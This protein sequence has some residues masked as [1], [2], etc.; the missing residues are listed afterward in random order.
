[1]TH[2]A[3]KIHVPW[4][5]SLGKNMRDDFTEKTR[6]ELRERVGGK[7]S[8]PDCRRETT[9]PLLGSEG[10]IRLGRA[11]HITAASRGGPRFDAALT[12]HQ[13]RSIHNGIWLCCDHADEVDTNRH[14]FPA[15]L[16]R[17]WKALAEDAAQNQLGKPPP[18]HDDAIH[19]VMSVL[20]ATPGKMLPRAM[21]NT[22]AAISRFLREK[23][24]TVQIIPEFHDGQTN[25]R[26]ESSSPIEIELSA[27]GR[28]Q[29]KLQ[30]A[31]TSIL[32]DGSDVALPLT[33]IAIKSS[34]AIELL[35]QGAKELIIGGVPRVGVL[36]VVLQPTDGDD[37]LSVEFCGEARHGSE[38]LSIAAS[39]FNGI[40]NVMFEAPLTQNRRSVKWT[41]ATSFLPWIGKS[42][43]ALPHLDRVTRFLRL[44]STNAAATLEVEVDG[45]PVAKAA[46]SG[47]TNVDW[48]RQHVGALEYVVDARDIIVAL[49]L[50]LPFAN[51]SVTSRDADEVGNVADLFRTSRKA[52][53]MHEDEEF[54]FR[55]RPSDQLLLQS[56]PEEGSLFK[57]VTPER[58]LSL[59]G[60]EVNVPSFTSILTGMKLTISAID[61]TS[62]MQK[63][64]AL[65]R[66]TP[67]A[68]STMQSW[69]TTQDL[70]LNTSGKVKSWGD[71]PPTIK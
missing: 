40:L 31:M 15:E 14:R 71:S 11:A 47:P 60:H 70:L 39:A 8:R 3:E 33:N 30:N 21:A 35:F 27:S 32:A 48:F 13:R 65:L 57:A 18:S 7:C 52:R 61:G 54:V 53:Q 58:S 55:I 69:L 5:T 46:I 34:P 10:S 12:R 67:S 43:G 28:A 56:Q 25:Y 6:R 17:E 51:F 45:L 68:R 24:A 22:S 20:G 62:P 19:Q 23:D 44:L 59:F 41:L 50:D 49:N 26:I 64:E 36:R 29:E 2:E 66:C 37:A 4:R 38:R 9:G 1:M 63:D 16:L 42:L